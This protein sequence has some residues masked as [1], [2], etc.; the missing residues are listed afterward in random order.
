MILKYEQWKDQNICGILFQKKSFCAAE[1]NLRAKLQHK[2]AFFGT[3]PEYESHL[4]PATS[5][6]SW[7]GC[8]DVSAELTLSQF[9]N[10]AR[11]SIDFCLVFCD[12]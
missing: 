1:W 2:K 3:I 4:E 6:F 9:R 5:G 8:T 12:R 10:P 11:A 7:E